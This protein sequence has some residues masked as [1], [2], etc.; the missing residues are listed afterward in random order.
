MS[1]AGRAQTRNHGRCDLT[2]KKGELLLNAIIFTA[3]CFCYFYVIPT[4]TAEVAIK[5]DLGPQMFPRFSMMIVM[6]GSFVLL[7]YGLLRIRKYGPPADS[8]FRA[9]VWVK[10]CVVVFLYILG[11]TYVGFYTSTFVFS[12]V[13][14]RRLKPPAYAAALATNL[15]LFALIWFGFEKMMKVALP[16]GLL[17]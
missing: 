13:Y 5:N 9:L 10:A 7:V 14:F 8:D 12:A 17:F 4:Y 16:A 1:R 2:L 11:V 15:V 6:V 3:S